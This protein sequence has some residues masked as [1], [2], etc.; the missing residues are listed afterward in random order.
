MIRILPPWKG[1]KAEDIWELYYFLLYSIL[2]FEPGDYLP[3]DKNG[4]YYYPDG[5]RSKGKAY[6]SAP[7]REFKLTEKSKMFLE[8]I[9]KPIPDSLEELIQIV[10]SDLHCYLYQD[11]RVNR[12]NLIE[13]LTTETDEQTLL[14]K[15]LDFKCTS[16]LAKLLLQYVFN[17]DNFSKKKLFPKLVQL[18]G[19]EVCPYCNRSFTST[20]KVRN[21]KYCRQNQIDHYRPKILFPWFALT[22][23]NL[24]PVCSN[25]N[26]RKGDDEE[27]VLYPYREG[28]DESYRFRTVPIL[29]IGYLTGQ[30]ASLDEFEI[31]IESKATGDLNYNTRAQKSIQKFGLDVL[32]RQSHNAYICAIF[33]Q[34]YIFDDAYLDSLVDSFPELFKTKEDVRRL[35]YMKQYTGDKLGFD[36]LAKLTYDIDDEISRLSTEKYYNF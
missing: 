36:P 3:K 30:P 35:L 6:P 29:G 26:L 9:D 5:D 34:R 22:L 19:I 12:K 2:P 4:F 31:H 17:Y 21:G 32:Y 20:V 27:F 18:M 28:F 1:D 11:H 7:F 8:Q 14:S 16:G 10:D 13:L 33:E 15:H 25:C 24:I 23:P